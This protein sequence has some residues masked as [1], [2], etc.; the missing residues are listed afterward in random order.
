MSSTTYTPDYKIDSTDYDALLSNIQSY[1]GALSNPVLDSNGNPIDY[2]GKTDGKDIAGYILCPFGFIAG[3]S[4]L[5]YPTGLSGNDV[6]DLLAAYQSAQAQ[7]DAATITAMSEAFKAKTEA[8]GAVN[9]AMVNADA[10]KYAADQ[11]VQA[12]IEQGKTD[13]YIAD[14]QADVEREKLEVERES[15][16][17]VDAI[18]AQANLI[19]AN[20]LTIEAEAKETTAEAKLEEAQNDSTSSWPG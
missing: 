18:N 20:A 8:E 9:A 13:K 7:I 19:S 16:E 11:Q 6:A 3:I 5:M 1:N 17:K 10:T 12:V 4:N 14:E 15:I 2:N